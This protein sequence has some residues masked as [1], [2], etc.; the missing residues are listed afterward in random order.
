V[1]EPVDPDDVL[2]LFRVAGVEFPDVVVT[3][4]HYVD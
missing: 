4:L 2:G 1:F 3:P